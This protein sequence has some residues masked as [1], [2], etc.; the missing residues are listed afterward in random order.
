MKIKTHDYLPEGEHLD[1][2]LVL[3]DHPIW[4]RGRV[5]HSGLLSN[6]ENVSGVEFTEFSAEDHA[7]LREYLVTVDGLPEPQGIMAAGDSS[8]VG[9]GRRLKDQGQRIKGRG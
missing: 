9:I 7:L 4:L 5:A 8:D 6:E 1:F 3:G 2:K